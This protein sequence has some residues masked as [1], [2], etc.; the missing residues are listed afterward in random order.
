MTQTEPENSSGS[1]CLFFP[2]WSLFVSPHLH[3]SHYHHP[4]HHPVLG[5]FPILAITQSQSHPLSSPPLLLAAHPCWRGKGGSYLKW[6]EGCR[7]S[8]PAAWGRR[9]KLSQQREGWE[10]GGSWD[11]LLGGVLPACPSPSAPPH[12]S[13]LAWEV[14]APLSLCGWR[15]FWL[16]TSFVSH[17]RNSG[18][19][20]LPVP[21]LSRSCCPP[22]Q[23]P[24]IPWMISCPDMKLCK[25]MEGHK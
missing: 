25:H 20:R 19:A 7:M 8:P 4:S 12:L 2:P 23:L 6:M 13:Y 22:G 21:G 24:S 5:I 10:A 3:P 1:C 17:L 9:Q 18:A 16:P 11:F 15:F 14:W